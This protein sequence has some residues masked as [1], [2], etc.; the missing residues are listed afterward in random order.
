MPESLA[1]GKRALR[2]EMSRRRQ[3]VPA[4]EAEAAGK[5]AARAFMANPRARSAV[6][7]AL[8]ADCAG[9]LPTRPL[10]DAIRQSGRCA[11]FPRVVA[12]RPLE[13]CTIDRWDEL[14]P[15]AYGL[16]EPGGDEPVV[17]LAVDDAVALPG[18]AFDA[19]GHRLGRGKAYYDR[20]FPVGAAG[21][22]LIGYGYAF[23]IVDR[24]PHDERDRAMDAIVTD[25]NVIDCAG[26]R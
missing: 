24:V 12:D 1:A 26:K 8:Y 25:R 16:L 2:V 13:F 9:E 23:Q 22:T 5:A 20:T 4:C 11:L 19:D 17:R 7:L 10:F 6:R 21:P 3:A 14:R 15:G 18:L